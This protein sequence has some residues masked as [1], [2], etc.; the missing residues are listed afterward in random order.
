MRGFVKD[1]E[2]SPVSIPEYGVNISY[3]QPIYRDWLRLRLGLEN[4]W[5]KEV[6]NKPRDSL[7]KFAIQLEMLFGKK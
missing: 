3:R 1:I 2:D 5:V 4:R 6:A 7:Y